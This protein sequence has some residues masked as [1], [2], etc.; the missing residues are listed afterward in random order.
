MKWKA[1]ENTL[2]RED[3]VD[4][5][6]D[7][8]NQVVQ[9]LGLPKSKYSAYIVGGAAIILRGLNEKKTADIDLIEVSSVLT[10]FL[11]D[12]GDGTINDRA[13]TCISDFSCDFYDRAL[14]LN[15]GT[16]AINFYVISLEDVIISKLATPRTK[17]R[18]D[19]R[20]EDVIKKVNWDLL[21]VLVKEHAKFALNK[22]RGS[23]LLAQYKE[24]LKD[25][26]EIKNNWTKDRSNKEFYD[27]H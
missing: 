14:R 13:D 7:F 25:V 12:Y 22:M 10:N 16:K 4:L 23:I 5:L 20:R 1:T 3:I 2:V 27:E 6:K 26:E 11:R 19:I 8:D 21:D 17:D 24:Y 9:K 15:I 18:I